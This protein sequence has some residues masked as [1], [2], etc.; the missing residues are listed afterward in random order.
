MLPW[1]SERITFERYMDFCLYDPQCGYY[2]NKRNIFGPSGDYYTS[3]YTHPFFAHCLGD[4]LAAFFERLGKPRPFQLVELGAGEGVLGRPLLDYLQETHAELSGC[5]SYVP[6]EV[7]RPALP[8]RIRGVVFGNEF[9]DALPVHRVRVRGSELREVYVAFD[10]GISEIEGELSDPRIHE[11]MKLGFPQWR[12]GYEYEANLRLL[13]VLQDLEARMDSGVLLT[14]D[15]G[16]EWEEYHTLPRA[17]GTWTC[18]YR[19]QVVLD[20]YVNIGRQDITAHVNFEVMKRMGERFGWKNQPLKSQRQFLME[21]GLEKRLLEEERQGWLNP[22]RLQRR[23]Q[24]KPLLAPGGISD[25][26]KVLIQ[27]IRC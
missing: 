3:P 20:P 12:D 16:Y 14:I 1:K 21:W 23:L 10:D 5:L 9:F 25:T 8:A 7:T 4:A 19:H 6:V 11:Y 15:Y 24:L 18:Y 2:T 27:E 17:G 26:L 13:D 22:E